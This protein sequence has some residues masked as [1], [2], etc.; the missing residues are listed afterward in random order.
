MKCWHPLQHSWTLGTFQ[1]QN[2]TNR[3]FHVVYWTSHFLKSEEV[4]TS[5][6]LLRALAPFLLAPEACV[7]NILEQQYTK[8]CPLGRK[9]AGQ[10]GD[11]TQHRLKWGCIRYG[12]H[13]QD[14][15]S[16]TEGGKLQPRASEE[17]YLKPLN[18]QPWVCLACMRSHSGKK[19]IQNK[20]Q[21]SREKETQTSKTIS[22]C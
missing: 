18:T 20:Y 6:H 12:Q 10:K 19:Q 13:R 7:F 4:V 9:E 14:N 8:V 5:S 15:K 2:K 16:Q 3:D 22:S 21:D 1:N 11:L 17:N